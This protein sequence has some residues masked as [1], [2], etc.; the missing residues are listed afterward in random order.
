M[1][2]NEAIA[3]AVSDVVATAILAIPSHRN[4]K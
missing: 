2:G 1:K 4:R 3:H